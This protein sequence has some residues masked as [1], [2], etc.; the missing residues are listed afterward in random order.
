MT[1]ET[2]KTCRTCAHRVGAIYAM[3]VCSRA[4]WSCS[5]EREYQR[6]CGKNFEGW[7][8]RPGLLARIRAFFYGWGPAK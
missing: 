2:P 8:Q 3:P 5:L 7:A 6:Q 4:G 1:I